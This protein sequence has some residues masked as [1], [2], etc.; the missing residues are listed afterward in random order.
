MGRDVLTRWA[1]GPDFTVAYG[2]HPDHVADVRLP[3]GEPR[4]AVLF[5]HGGFW[6]QEYDRVHV[7][8]LAV[9][10]AAAGFVVITPEFR[11]TGAPGGGW[12]GTFD[13]VVTAARAVP[14]QVAA[15]LP[16]L[17]AGHSA[18]GQLALWVGAQ[19]ARSGQPPHG[20]LALAPV[21]DLPAAYELDLDGGAV[22]TLLGGGP[23]EAP[24]RYAAADPLALLPLGVA[25][26][27]GHGDRDVVVPIELSRRFADAARAAGD[28][29]TLH[30]WPGV[31]HF[32]IIDPESAIWPVVVTV[33]QQ[34]VRG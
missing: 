31:D 29:M 19:L 12:P 18:G 5:L 6:R 14:P 7:G 17:L 26:A 25:M 11:R 3:P 21:V 1:P 34:L 33:F 30:E 10:L 20:V 9:A 32:D 2:E 24:E 8:P 23:T 27:I 28:S 15:G 16:L 4:A 22:A 13:D